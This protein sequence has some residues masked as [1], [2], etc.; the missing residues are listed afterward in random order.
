M[1]EIIPLVVLLG[2]MAFTALGVVAWF[3][4]LFWDQVKELRIRYAFNTADGPKVETLERLIGPLDTHV[5]VSLDTWSANDA[6]EYWKE[7]R[8]PRIYPE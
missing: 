1:V 5:L 6:I 7:H 4:S 2:V 3:G 8:S